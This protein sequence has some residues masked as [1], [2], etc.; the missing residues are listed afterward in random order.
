MEDVVRIHLGDAFL[1]DAKNSFAHDTLPIVK[2]FEGVKP[3][4]R[5]LLSSHGRLSTPGNTST[6]FVETIEEEPGEERSTSQ[7]EIM[8]IHD[9][10]SEFHKI[11]PSTADV[12][13]E[14]FKMPV[15]IGRGESA[16]TLF[17]LSKSREKRSQWRK[18][19]IDGDKESIDSHSIEDEIDD[20]LSGSFSSISNSISSNKH[21]SAKSRDS[22][23]LGESA[24]F[25]ADS[26]KLDVLNLP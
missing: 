15:K 1:F 17:K 5:N 21:R 4:C 14:N 22:G 19:N 10:G 24:N 6:N 16:P 9:D 12:N 13:T 18:K 26:S 11:R 2:S 23:Y 3:F 20:I 7:A 8:R 25:D